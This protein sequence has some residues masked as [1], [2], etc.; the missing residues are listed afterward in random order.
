MITTTIDEETQSVFVAG[1]ALE[2]V[3]TARGLKYRRQDVQAEYARRVALT[4]SQ[5]PN[6][7][8]TITLLEGETGIGKSLGYLVP[9]CLQLARTGDRGLIST[10]TRLLQSQI[11]END[12]PIATEIAERRFQRRLKGALRLGMRNFISAHRVAALRADLSQAHLLD[13][14]TD[15]TLSDLETYAQSEGILRNWVQVNGP[16]PPHIPE[17]AIC[18]LSSNATDADRYRSHIAISADADIVI[19]THALLV[20]SLLRWH[21]VLG[22]GD[23]ETPPFAAGIIDEGDQFR[24]AAAEILSTRVSVPMLDS[25]A[26]LV[27]VSD[28][29]GLRKAIAHATSWF[30]EALE[31]SSSLGILRSGSSGRSVNLGAREAAPLRVEA[32]E[33]ARRLANAL[34]RLDLDQLAHDDAVEISHLVAGLT[35]FAESC[36]TIADTAP[37]LRWSPVRRYAGFAV[38]P[39]H[40][41]QLASRLWNTRNG[42]QPYLKSLVIT[43]ATLD[44]P[45]EG[46]HAFRSFKAEIGLFGEKA[47]N[48]LSGRFSPAKFGSARFVFADPNAPFPSA[49]HQEEVETNPLWVTYT[50]AGLKEIACRGGRA[51]VLTTSFRDAAHLCTASRLIGV[52]PLIEHRRGERISE[53]LQTLR[54]TENGILVTPSAWEGVNLPG[55]LSHVVATRLPFPPPD[56]AERAALLDILIARGWGLADAQRAIFRSVMYVAMRRYKQGFGRG[57]RAADDSFTFWC[58]DPRLPLPDEVARRHNVLQPVRTRKYRHFLAC[59]PSRFVGGIR[60]TLH[61]AEIFFHRPSVPAFRT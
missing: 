47:V 20:R 3:M 44:A 33:I 40:P 42:S 23:G 45:G 17:E 61:E 29:Q 30:D 35:D 48:K 51:L 12:L 41:G 1:G 43:S 2:S 18:L 10:H 4:L 14:Q 38:V 13:D 56:D 31:Q 60:G 25:V 19:V 39:L 22:R 34:Q 46:E 55:V 52:A 58:F 53:L 59:I 7:E 57:I 54:G 49:E 50:A 15:Q 5:M 24:D 21:S 32:V 8:T 26:Q 16:L 27:N 9:L 28:A 37:V 6:P 11:L 36:G